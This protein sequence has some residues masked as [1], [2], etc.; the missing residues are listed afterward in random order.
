M[1]DQLLTERRLPSFRSREEMLE[2]LLREEYG[3]LPPK[4]EK[5]SWKQ[6]EKANRK[7]C[8]GKAT[9]NKMELTAEF[10]GKSF[11]FPVYVTVPVGEGKFPFFIH[12]NFRDCV[13]DLYMPT[14]EIVDHGFAVLSFCYKDITADND[15][16]SDG[17]AGVLY[18]DGERSDTDAG[19]IAIWAWAAHRVMDYAET[20]E[21]LDMKRSIVCGHSRLGKTALLTAATD[22]RFAYGYSNDSGCCGASLSRGRSAGGETVDVI[23]G[24][25]PYWFCKRFYQY[26]KNEDQMPFDQH[27]LLA[28][29]APRYVYVAD[30][31]E[32]AWADPVSSFLNC[33]AVSPLY[34]SSYGKRG[35]I[36]EGRLPQVGDQY[37]EGC[38]GYHMRGGQHYFSREDW[39]GIM[40]FVKK[41]SEDT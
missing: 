19:K 21:C 6:V 11:S 34:E 35:L 17:L 15:D 33:C 30:A 23:T 3:Y 2:C 9:M 41:H 18:P 24:T 26:A 10:N 28:S 20:L 32:D 1:I 5:L 8:A 13:P 27:W 12:V 25:F 29:I 39:L 38:I 7:F 22:E 31:A 36:H 4:P 16:F 37:H 14:E 40:K